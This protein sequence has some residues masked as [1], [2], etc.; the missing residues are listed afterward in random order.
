MNIKQ[1]ILDSVVE[2]KRRKN[3]VLALVLEK[4]KTDKE[5]DF[6]KE[7]WDLG[8][9]SFAAIGV[10][11]TCG[12]ELVKLAGEDDYESFHINDGFTE[13]ERLLLGDDPNLEEIAENI[14]K[15]QKEATRAKVENQNKRDHEE[16]QKLKEKLQ[17]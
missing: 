6:D 16:Y 12:E 10:S 11:F 5:F 13:V 4:S 1:T 15:K 8:W 17:L 14:I 7:K 2:F 3:K 9:L